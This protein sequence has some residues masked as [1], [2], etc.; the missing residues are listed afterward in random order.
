MDG[1]RCQISK[2]EKFRKES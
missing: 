2:K 1:V